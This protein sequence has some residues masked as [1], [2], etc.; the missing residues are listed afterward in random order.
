MTLL[1]A[2]PRLQLVMALLVCVASVTLLAARLHYGFLPEDDPSFSYLGERTLQ[3]GLPNVDF[4]DN[5]TGGMSFLN[6]FALRVFGLRMVSLR[7]MLLL[8][9]VPWIATVWY[10]ASRITSS[11][12]ALLLTLV[13]AIWSVP[14]YPTSYATWYNLYF[15][16]FG[17]AALFRFSDTRRW[18]WI[19]WAGICG[20]LSFLA[21]I[22]GLYLVAAAGLFLLFDEQQNSAAAEDVENVRWSAYSIF[23][24]LLILSFVAAV[25]HLIHV[26]DR[27]DG[28]SDALRRYYHF[29]LPIG[30]VGVFLIYSEWKIARASSRKRFVAAAG[31]IGPFSL[32][33]AVPIAFFLIPYIGRHV[34]GQW[35]AAVLLARGRVEHSSNPPASNAFLILTVPLLLFLL[36]NSEF[37]L[38]KTRKVVAAVLSALLGLLLILGAT[39]HLAS[40]LE[41]FSIVESLPLLVVI[42]LVVIARKGLTHSG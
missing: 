32:G 1:A 36:I 8:F 26:A 31:R 38:G 21:K 37:R 28:L 39:H 12:N 25:I 22:F 18:R 9:F 17:T 33:V 40:A 11:I 16:T 7:F 3:G 34:V 5:Y 15:A 24:T 35:L 20:G 10:L 4:Y 42:G 14:V 6:A 19:F 13:A 23:L 29:V 2:A 41:W 27:S 30:A